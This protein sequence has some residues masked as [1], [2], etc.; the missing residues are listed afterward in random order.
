MESVRTIAKCPECGSAAVRFNLD[1][2]AASVSSIRVALADDGSL[3]LLVVPLNS[4]DEREPTAADLSSGEWA[5]CASCTTEDHAGRF[6]VSEPEPT[7]PP[8]FKC[9]NC[10]S[11]DVYG[12]SGASIALND[13]KATP[14][15]DIC[16]WDG[17]HCN[18]CDE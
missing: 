16:D 11:F 5:W 3:R 15:L 14:S 2:L 4:T 10:G 18:A 17:A 1:A 12:D 8:Q 7:Y 13:P 9:R 6:L